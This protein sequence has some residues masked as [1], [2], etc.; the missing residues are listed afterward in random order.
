MNRTILEIDSPEATAVPFTSDSAADEVPSA[1]SA[2]PRVY[3]SLKERP[4]DFEGYFA[5]ARRQHVEAVVTYKALTE[6]PADFQGFFAPPPGKCIEGVAT[7]TAMKKRPE[8]PLDD[9]AA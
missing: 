4:A 8:A 9:I 3:I 7:Y 6:R 5:P 1:A 2:E